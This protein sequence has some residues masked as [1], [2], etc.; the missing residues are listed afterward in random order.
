MTGKSNYPLIFKGV[1]VESDQFGDYYID[2]EIT[3]SADLLG[4]CP[5]FQGKWLSFNIS[6]YCKLSE[7]HNKNK[8]REFKANA[9]ASLIETHN[10]WLELR[11]PSDAGD[12]G[13][14]DR[15]FRYCFE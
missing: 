15:H 5:V 3:Q 2:G 12:N 10:D 7:F 8:D 9:I 14:K 6:N 11:K 13:N 4:D 1:L